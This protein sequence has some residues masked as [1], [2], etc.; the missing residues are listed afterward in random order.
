MDLVP[1]PSQTIGPF[2]HCYFDGYGT[3]GNLAGAQAKGERIRLAFR[4][5]DGDGAPLN[6]AMLELWQADI[7]A[8]GRLPT[9]ESGA[10]VFETIKPG[11]MAP[12]AP[13]IN[14]SVF[15]RGLLNR[16]V[17]RVYFA[18]DPAN[19]EDA[20]LALVPDDRRETLMA[21]AGGEGLWNFEI[22]LCGERETVFFDV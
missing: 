14:V 19:R 20:V 5:L 10:C 6:D 4:V 22:R 17:T 8:F 11:R 18:G 12:Q 13:H 9:D 3:M 1:S 21:H 16:L 15:A 2:F 7:G